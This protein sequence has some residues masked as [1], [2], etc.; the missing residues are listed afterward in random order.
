MGNE[1]LFLL[2]ISVAVLLGY[3]LKFLTVSGCIAALLVGILTMLGFQLKGL[4]LLGVFFVTS[5]LWSKYKRI[6]KS[7]AEERHAKGS[8]RDWQQVFANGGVAAIIAFGYFM[9]PDPLWAFAFCVLIASSN[10]DTWASEIGT[11]SRKSP[12][13]VRTFKFVARGTSG[14]VS[15]LGTTA[16]L[17]GALLIAII[18]FFL[19]QWSI[20]VMLLIFVFGFLGNVIDTFLGAY[21]Q[22]LYKCQKCKSETEKITHCGQRTRLIRGNAFLNNDIINFLSSFL[23]TIIG[24][25]VFQSIT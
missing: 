15:L 1:F 13:S 7:K 19:F 14:A 23:A 11:L 22:A 17:G 16:A 9:Y 2:I 6:Y 8:R 12:I 18:S 5:S 24:I 20:N 25:L 3:R 21:V 4:S 10:S